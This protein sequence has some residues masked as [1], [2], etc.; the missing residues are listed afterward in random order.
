MYSLLWL[1]T[2]NRKSHFNKEI[3]KTNLE[4]SLDKNQTEKNGNLM[5]SIFRE[6]ML[7]FFYNSQFPRLKESEGGNLSFTHDYIETSISQ[8]AITFVE[9]YKVV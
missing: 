7:K 5:W 2:H 3:C 4:N 6:G 8:N 1:G 9:A